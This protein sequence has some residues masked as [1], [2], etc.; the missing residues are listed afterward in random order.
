[1]PGRWGV[2]RRTDDGLCIPDSPVVVP[3][4]ADP[5]APLHHT[6]CLNLVSFY[7]AWALRRGAPAQA[8]ALA[9][10]SRPRSTPRVLQSWGAPFQVGL[11][12][13]F[14]QGTA[15]RVATPDERCHL[16]AREHVVLAQPL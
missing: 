2:V 10:T 16:G 7:L 5:F 13:C 12:Q 1:M 3:L 9:S 15:T 4:L 14:L 6:D 11:M 8:Q